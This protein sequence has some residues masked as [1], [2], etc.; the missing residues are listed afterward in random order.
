MP[1][2]WYAVGMFVAALLA[3]EFRI[4]GVDL[5]VWLPFAVLLPLSCVIVWS[6]GRGALEI[7][8]GEV[9]IRGAH[10]PL[11]YVS[12]AVA[13]DERTLRLVVGREGDPGGVRVD[14][15]VDRS[16]RAA[17]A[18][19]PG[20]PGA[21]LGREQPP[22]AASGRSDPSRALRSGYASR[23]M[24]SADTT[25]PGRRFEGRV[26]LVTGASRGIGLAVAARIVA[27]G[28]RVVITARKPEGL[29]D[30]L[31]TL[32]A[33]AARSVAGRADDAEHQ[34]D[35]VATAVREFGRLDVLVNNTGINPAYGPL[36]E[37]DEGAARKI[38]DVNVL[39]GAV[40]DAAGARR[41]ARRRTPARRSSTSPRWPACRRHPASRGTA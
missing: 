20:G 11:R 1:L 19:R 18:R 32:G 4:A 5:T 2:W 36:T 8:G 34:A 23:L 35:A 25:A 22:P 10:L 33:D 30:A 24:T 7:S 12:G 31:A 9:R 38:I 21:V 29:A 40:V 37:L 16:R 14:P 41:G 39:A 13:L 26:A 15:A 28:G 3:A 27:E 6:F 17:V